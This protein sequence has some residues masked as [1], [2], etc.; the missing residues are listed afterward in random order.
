LAAAIESDSFLSK[1]L[2]LAQL[3]RR[4]RAITTCGAWQFSIAFPS[5]WGVCKIFIFT[6]DFTGKMLSIKA[7]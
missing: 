3:S 5:A 1:M 2:D 7:A 6:T 4:L